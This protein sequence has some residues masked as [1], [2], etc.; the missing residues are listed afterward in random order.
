ML[1]NKHGQ[2]KGSFDKYSVI[3]YL[4]GLSIDIRKP[5]IIRIYESPLKGK[6]T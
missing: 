5:I 2:K 3:E 1:I 6:E 4:T